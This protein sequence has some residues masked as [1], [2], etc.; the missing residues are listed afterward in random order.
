MKASFGEM[1]YL[2]SICK[3]AFAMMSLQS[4]TKGLHKERHYYMYYSYTNVLLFIIMYLYN[5]EIS[6][7]T[8]L[9]KA[10]FLEKRF[11]LH[12]ILLVETGFPELPDLEIREVVESGI[13]SHEIVIITDTLL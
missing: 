4:S 9:N 5:D 11:S 6:F 7:T 2:T 8:I 10:T 3:Q 13:R 1:P 12:P